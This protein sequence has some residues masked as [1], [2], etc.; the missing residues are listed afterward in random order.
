MIEGEA[1]MPEAIES[2]YRC[3]KNIFQA[4]MLL[5]ELLTKEGHTL[6]RFEVRLRLERAVGPE[7]AV[8]YNASAMRVPICRRISEGL[9]TRSKEW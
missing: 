4:L 9:R 3:R 8:G 2:F 7:N 6:W 1:G 5:R